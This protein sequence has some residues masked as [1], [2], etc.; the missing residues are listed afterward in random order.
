VDGPRTVRKAGE[1]AVASFRRTVETRL[2]ESIRRDPERAADA[3]EIGLVDREWLESPQER[4][5]RV[6]PPV[7]LLKRSI[8]KLVERR[9]SMLS[10]LG[11]NALQILA[12][13][14]GRSFGSDEPVRVAVV[15]TDLEG[16][17]SYTADVGDA[18]AV[19]L[20][21]EHHRAVSPIVRS[22]GGRVVKRLGDGLMLSFPEP[23]AAVMAALEL[24]TTA[25]GPLRLRAGAHVGEVMASRDDL[26]G[27]VVNVAARVAEEAKGGEVL[28]TADICD[29][30]V[31]LPG[32]SFGRRRR[33]SLKGV[34]D[35]VAVC[36]VTRATDR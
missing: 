26:L 33:L 21:E 24:V 31:G 23:E 35:R 34:P 13:E 3:I 6:A 14:G 22:R 5:F 1:K 15:F 36:R 11:L 7:E 8:E 4:P 32:A 20:L 9:P 17:T 18:A 27:H 19:E 25:P 10:S 16:F 29:A 28:V 12:W 2:A 30:A